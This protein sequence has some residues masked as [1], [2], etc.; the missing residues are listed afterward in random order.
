MGK[1]TMHFVDECAPSNDANSSATGIGYG[2]RLIRTK[3]SAIA[4]PNVAC[5]EV[6]DEAA[7]DI[8]N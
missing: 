8:V 1:R 7:T 5:V 3:I 4:S 2:T 6:A